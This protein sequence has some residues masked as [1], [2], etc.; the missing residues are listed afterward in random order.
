MEWITIIVRML[1]YTQSDLVSSQV[2]YFLVTANPYDNL[3]ILFK[4]KD[5]FVSMQLFH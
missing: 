3:N 2:P 1:W 4:V 5:T